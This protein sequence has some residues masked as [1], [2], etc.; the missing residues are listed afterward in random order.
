[1]E[2]S[3][4]LEVKLFVK[5]WHNKDWQNMSNVKK[6]IIARSEELAERAYDE[7]WSF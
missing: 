2:S 4:L 3:N 5:N 7:V 6:N 1:V